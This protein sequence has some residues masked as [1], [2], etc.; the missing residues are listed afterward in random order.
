MIVL[1][2]RTSVTIIWKQ[3][4]NAPG[5]SDNGGSGAVRGGGG[6]SP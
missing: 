4:Q 6:D 5:K 2:Y 1:D 3:L